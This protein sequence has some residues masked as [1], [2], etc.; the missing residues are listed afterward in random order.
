MQPLIA[1]AILHYLQI[2]SRVTIR[3]LAPY[4]DA[5]NPELRSFVRD[6]F[7]GHDNADAGL[8]G[9]V[10]Y[11]DYL[12]YVRGSVNR[13]EELPA[14]FIKYIYE[15]SPGRALMVFAEGTA[16]VSGH[17]KAL[18]MNFE[19]H[20]Q[21]RALTEEER[22]QIRQ[23]QA[24]KKIEGRGRRQILLVAHIV[25]NAIWLHKNAYIVRFQKALPEANEALAM[26]AE[27]GDW[28]ARFY[29]AHLMRRNRVLRQEHIMRQLAEDGNPLVREA[30]GAAAAE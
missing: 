19:A 14:P 26:L 8:L 1:G 15:R 4:L 2:P 23:I 5:T 10:N 29:V 3:T 20:Q 6:W 21:G 13:G 16:N 12:D 11:N 22:E 27:H 30:V 24:K 17:L 18:R 28:W 9:A 25:G 7:R